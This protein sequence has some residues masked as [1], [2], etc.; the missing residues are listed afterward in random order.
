MHSV[1]NTE[2]EIPQIPP[3]PLPDVLASL[4]PNVIPSCMLSLLQILN[5][6]DWASWPWRDTCTQLP[7]LGSYLHVIASTEMEILQPLALQLQEMEAP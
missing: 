7:Q 3:L 1:I 2:G 4:L 6:V 5:I